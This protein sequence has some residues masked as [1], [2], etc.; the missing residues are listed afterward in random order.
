MTGERIFRPSPEFAQRAHIKSF[1]QYQ[2]MYRRS[3]EDPAGFW[4]EIAQEFYWQ[5]KWNKF[6][7]WDF[8]GNISIKYFIGGRTNICYNA[9]DRHLDR[10]GDQVA[11]L[12]EGNEP[13]E[14]RKL[15]YR[16]LHARSASSPT[17]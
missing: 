11:I 1:E 3:I 12:W 10:R 15:T 13:G 7:E 17:C 14:E 4:G 9:L 5:Q 8:T 2:A 16:Q 6:C